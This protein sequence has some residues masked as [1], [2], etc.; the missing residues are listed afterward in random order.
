M[1]FV[2]DPLAPDR[3]G[4]R[5]L[6]VVWLAQQVEWVDADMGRDLLNAL[7][8]QVAFATFD[9][10][11]VRPVDAEHVGESLLAETTGEPVSAQVAPHRSLQI[12][13]GQEPNAGRLLLDSLQTYK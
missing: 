9:A 7:Q 5:S 1:A 3:E 2:M 13:F 8:R 4:R 10:A 12:A 6:A 11:H